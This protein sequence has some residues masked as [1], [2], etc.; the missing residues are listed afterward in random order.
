MDNMRVTHLFEV[1][2]QET[3]TGPLNETV[4]VGVGKLDAERAMAFARQYT[5]YSN[6]WRWRVVTGCKYLGLLAGVEG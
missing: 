6:W 2:V 3:G 1:Y 5:H 4:L